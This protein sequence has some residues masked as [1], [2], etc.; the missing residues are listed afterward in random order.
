[1]LLDQ[2]D[3]AVYQKLFI[4]SVKRGIADADSGKVYTTE[5]LIEE[6]EK[7]RLKRRENENRQRR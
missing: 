6:L 2:S 3:S 1:M 4:D 7:R 5:E